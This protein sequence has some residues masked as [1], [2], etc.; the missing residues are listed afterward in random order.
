MPGSSVSAVAAELARASLPWPSIS[1]VVVDDFYVPR[2][3]IDPAETDP[4]LIVDA[5]AVLALAIALQRLECVTGRRAELL[6]R[7]RSI[8]D[9]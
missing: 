5:D 8:Q 7:L 3:S 6:E 2:I 1:L 4:P 9:E